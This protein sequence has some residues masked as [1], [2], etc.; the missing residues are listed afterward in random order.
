MAR[1]PGRAPVS[2]I[3]YDGTTG[4]PTVISYDPGSTTGWALMS[5]HPEALV[6]PDVRI[7]SNVEHMSFGQFVG[8]EYAQVDEMLALA[9]EWPGAALIIEDFV[10]RRFD[11]G[12]EVLSPVRITAAFRYGL[13]RG[14]IATRDKEGSFNHEASSWSAG[15]IARSQQASL[16]MTTMTDE[17]LQRVGFYER[18]SGKPHA[19][20]ALRHTITFLKRLKE[21]SKL[22]KEVFPYLDDVVTPSR[23]AS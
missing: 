14:L 19:R 6:K 11:A 13:S 8:T 21:N 1:K 2:E 7:L 18:T 16:A 5:V 15:R 3:R 23:E 9:A 22:R 20:D 10:L 4:D 12:R 17:R